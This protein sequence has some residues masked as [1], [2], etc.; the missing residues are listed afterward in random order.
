MLV[1]LTDTH[2]GE[3]VVIKEPDCQEEDWPPPLWT[4]GNL[5]CDCTRAERFA[6]AKGE[7]APS[8]PLRCDF[9]RYRVEIV[10][11]KLNYTEHL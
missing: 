11:G 7:P 5:A 9:T 1:R 4:D 8:P 6:F 3:T 10:Q 2:T